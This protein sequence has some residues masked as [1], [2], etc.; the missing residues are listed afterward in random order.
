MNLGQKMPY[1]AGEWK[2]SKT[3]KYIVKIQVA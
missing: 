3:K 2:K 1:F